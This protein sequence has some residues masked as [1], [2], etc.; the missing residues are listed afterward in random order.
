MGNTNC[1]VQ[2]MHVRGYSCPAHAIPEYSCCL[3][4]SFMPDKV[5]LRRQE[6]SCGSD[7]GLSLR[8]FNIEVLPRLVHGLDATFTAPHRA[9]A[10][11]P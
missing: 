1:H 7:T 9:V 10:L 3:Q 2:A 8:T 6:L 5:E 11:E 4:S